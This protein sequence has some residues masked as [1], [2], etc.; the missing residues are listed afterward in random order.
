MLDEKLSNLRY[1][2][3]KIR[4]FDGDARYQC[5]VSRDSMIFIVRT[6]NRT[7]SKIDISPD[8]VNVIGER[9]V[10]FSGDYRIEKEFNLPSNREIQER[11]FMLDEIL[12]RS[13]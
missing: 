3:I 7:I 1:G 5:L 4:E 10:T 11:Y 8:N 6:G 13:K 9:E 12:K 2:K